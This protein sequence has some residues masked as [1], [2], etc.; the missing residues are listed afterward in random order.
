MATEEHIPILGLKEFQL[1]DGDHHDFLY[2]EIRGKR[3]IEK[4]HKHDFFL[5]LLFEKGSGTHTI[6]F[7]DHKITNHQIHLLFPN[8]VH[9]WVLGKDTSAFQVMISRNVFENLSASLRF[10]FAL[11]QHHPVIPLPQQLFETLLYEFDAI[12]K[13]LFLKPV[14][15]A[16]VNLR[17]R[18]IAQLVSREAEGKFEDMVIYD[19]NPLLYKFLNLIDAHLREQKSVAFYAAQLNISANYLNILCRKHLHVPATY[20]IHNRVVLEAKRLVHAT[21]K[22][23]KEIS[24]ELGFNDPAYFSNFFKAQTGLSPRQFRDQ[25]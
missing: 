1:N 13:E 8:Q 16:I 23:L 2:H 3:V 21:D 10:S 22:S 9:K 24:F 20:I 6:D 4:P 18:I 17:S 12:Q 5:F 7:V 15:T 11:Y 14:N 19:A 25:L